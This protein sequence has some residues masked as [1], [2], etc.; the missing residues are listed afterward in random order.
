M[1]WAVDLC[2]AL[3]IVVSHIAAAAAQRYAAD[4]R[5]CPVLEPRSNPPKDIGDL[6]PDDI[7]VI[8]A[9]GDSVTAGFGAKLI[10][11]LDTNILQEYRGLSFS[12]GGD[13]N[14]PTIGN[15][16]KHY[17]P[18][19]VGQSRGNHFIELCYDGVF[20]APDELAYRPKQDVFNAAL[21]GAISAT[22]GLET[23]Y[24]LGQV[25]RHHAVNVTTDWKML[26]LFIGNNELCH[27]SCDSREDGEP[28]TASDFELRVIATLDIIQQRLPRTLVNILLLPD[29]SQVE[30]FANN[31]IR[32]VHARRLLA[33]ICPCAMK[34][35]EAGRWAMRRAA[36]DYN[37][38]LKGIATRFNLQAKKSASE[39][40]KARDFAVIITPVMKDMDIRND[41]PAHFA[42]K[43]DCFHPSATAHRS[44]AMAVCCMKEEPSSHY[45]QAEEDVVD[46]EYD[47]QAPSASASTMRQHSGSR[48]AHN[49]RRSSSPKRERRSISPR[50]DDEA[51]GRPSREERRRS[52]PRGRRHPSPRQEE[53]RAERSPPRHG[54]DRRPAH[55]KHREDKY[56]N[57]ERQEDRKPNQS[58]SR[59][60]D[61]RRQ[62]TLHPNR[63]SAHPNRDSAHRHRDPSHPN[64]DIS[65]RNCNSPPR[66][67]SPLAR[68]DKSPLRKRPRSPSAPRRHESTR[69]KIS[70]SPPRTNFR[71]ASPRPEYFLDSTQD[72][73]QRIVRPEDMERVAS[74]ALSE[75]RH[76]REPDRIRMPLRDESPSP[77]MRQ[78][79]DDTD[80][81]GNR[82]RS[83]VPRKISMRPGGQEYEHHK[84][85]VIPVHHDVRPTSL[86]TFD[87]LLGG[88]KFT[89][90]L[91][92]GGEN[93]FFIARCNYYDIFVKAKR[94]ALW[95]AP[96]YVVDRIRKAAASADKVLLFF[97]VHETKYFQEYPNATER[98]ARVPLT[99]LYI[100]DVPFYQ[101]HQINGLFDHQGDVKE[102]FEVNP[103]HSGK[104]LVLFEKFARR[105]TLRGGTEGDVEENVDAKE[106]DDSHNPPKGDGVQESVRD[107]VQD[108]IKEGVQDSPGESTKDNPGEH[109]G[110]QE[111]VEGNPVRNT[112]FESHM[113]EE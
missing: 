87:L 67:R 10:S 16:I 112:D 65:H 21:S 56:R 33:S 51:R 83:P 23:R 61:D 92:G 97:S 44:L 58:P 80:Y 106:Q 57:D 52:P 71:R 20:C 75:S 91:V 99:W 1:L 59:Y 9:L 95:K 32:C 81:R 113:A 107:G 54:E 53:R 8:M 96:E 18:D 46:F 90:A 55:L 49:T 86:S 109:S 42:A 110:L 43:L 30:Y 13:P 108:G 28:G 29:M 66:G 79:R 84:R 68:K 76:Y 100:V 25:V 26:T 89:E 88:V 12:I 35:G 93:R 74:E 6:R 60:R 4:I 41:V 70:N 24:L 50:Q 37:E 102:S 104:I 73:R 45:Y 98:L 17:R 11:I 85:A 103:D 62:D 34:K 5:Q 77:P 38:R 78:S 63:G 14:A 7:G 40:G 22:L 48:E 27:T 47:E 36:A 64:R 111:M 31:H 69:R 15:F 82:G 94:S 2:L 105:M 19:L 3:T 72:A 101:V 39:T